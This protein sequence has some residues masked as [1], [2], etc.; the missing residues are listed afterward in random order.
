MRLRDSPADLLDQINCR[1][2]GNK[3]PAV[4]TPELIETATGHMLHSEIST[5]AVRCF[6]DICVG[7]ADDVRMFEVCKQDCLAEH[8]LNLVEIHTDTFEN[9]HG[10]P[11]KK[12]MLDAINLRER[13]FAQ[14]AF[15]FVRIANHLAVFE[16]AHKE[17]NI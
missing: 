7:N 9:F 16:Q 12:A 5:S 2:D 11:A 3:L 1:L 13:S 14:E 6:K 15:H 10:L 8:V 4:R 17:E